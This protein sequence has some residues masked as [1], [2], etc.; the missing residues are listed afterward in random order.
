MDGHEKVMMRCS[1]AP[2]RVGRPR[3]NGHRLKYTNGW[4]MVTDPRTSRILGLAAQVE[5]ENNLL[6]MKILKR[7]MSHYENCNCLIHDRN[8]S[9]MGTAKT[10]AELRCIK[11]YA[12]DQFHGNKH[13][14]TCT[15]APKNVK[16]IATRLRGINTSVSEQVFS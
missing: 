14:S 10:D 2:P 1:V 4:F 7:I 3:K 12:T 6:K 9:F 5:P 16:R 11:Y 13:T 15:C 8:C